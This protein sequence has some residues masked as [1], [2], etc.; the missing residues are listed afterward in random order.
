MACLGLSSLD[1]PKNPAV[2]VMEAASHPAAQLQPVLLE[3]PHAGLPLP[4]R[5]EP[6]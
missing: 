4:D 1:E 2:L 3:L 5:Q 6:P